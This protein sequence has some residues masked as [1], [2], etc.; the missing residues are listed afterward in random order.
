MKIIQSQIL[1]TF[2]A[3]KIFYANVLIDPHIHLAQL[4]HCIKMDTT[5][6]ILNFKTIF[7][8]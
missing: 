3:S 8:F 6:P 7:S 5:A 4:K 2:N 1:I